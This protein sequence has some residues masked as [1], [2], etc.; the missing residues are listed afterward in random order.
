[1]TAPSD[2]ILP[3]NFAA[4]IGSALRLVVH[5][6]LSGVRAGIPV[7]NRAGMVVRFHPLTWWCE[8][9]S[10]GFKSRPAHFLHNA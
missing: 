4:G 5:S 8:T 10:C 1:M 2:I 9:G 3:R 6:F 7:I